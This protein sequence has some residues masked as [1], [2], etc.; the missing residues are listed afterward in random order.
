LPQPEGP[1][2]PPR[3]KHN[4][5]K[6]VVRYYD[7]QRDGPVK[8]ERFVLSNLKGSFLSR[9]RSVREGRS[10]L[11]F[12]GGAYPVEKRDD[13]Y[14]VLARKPILYL[15][16]G[17]DL[18]HASEDLRLHI[19]D[20]STGTYYYFFRPAAPAYNPHGIPWDNMHVC[21]RVLGVLWTRDGVN[22]NRRFISAPDEND[23]VGAQ[24]YN[25]A[26]PLSL[27]ETIAA[28][29]GLPSV[30]G[31][32]RV[33]GGR[34]YVGSFTF[35]DA[36]AGRQWPEAVWTADFLHWH[37]FTPRR[38]MIP[39]GPVESYNHG[40]IKLGRTYYPFGRQWWYLY[41][42]INQPKQHYTG[43]ARCPSAEVLRSR[44][45][46]YDKM[47][48]FRP[49]NNWTRFHEHCRQVRYYP[50]IARCPAGRLCHAEPTDGRGELVT[51]A[52]RVG[53]ASPAINAVTARG[54][55]I[56]IEIL[57]QKGMPVPGF[58][59]AECRAFTGDSVEHAVRW[60]EADYSQLAGRM[61]RLRFIL[62]RAKLYA[63]RF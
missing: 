28:G 1:K 50:A 27:R 11:R 51:A 6:A 3:L 19:H 58:G 62:D 25:M 13:L 31:V 44:H 55:S 45:P 47:P 10:E 2:G 42:A 18:Y 15:G 57:D 4:Y 23:P 61:L 30:G 26:L 59:A 34:V 52:L 33:R 63:Y 40:M 48:S 32:Y 9:I 12:T 17:M 21:R 41:K 53:A 29:Q 22:W 35:Y 56:R 38:K 16:V 37:R 54:G 14:L 43:M 39:N 20:R 36:R 49:F 60:K 8:M 5:D 7:P 46:Q 24:Y